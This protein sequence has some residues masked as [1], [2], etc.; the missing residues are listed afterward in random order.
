MASPIDPID[1]SLSDVSS[2]SFSYTVPMI[3]HLHSPSF[4]YTSTAGA[5]FNY[6]A[7][8]P[9]PIGSSEVRKYGPW[10]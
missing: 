2:P 10:I 9:Q 3:L 6:R 1:P 5:S 8:A 7:L 4:N